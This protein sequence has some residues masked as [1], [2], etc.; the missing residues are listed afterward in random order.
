M[1]SVTYQIDSAHTHAQFKVR[2][3]MISN[4]RGEFSKVTGT[5]VYDPD[6]PSAAQ[7]NATID[8]STIS[9]R[10]PQRDEHLK[11]GDFFDVARHP[12]ITFASKEVTASGPESFE[13]TGDLTIRGT[14]RQVAL[15]VEDVTPEAKDPWGN[16]RRGASAKTRIVRKDFGLEWNMALE[17]GGF[18]VG[19]EVEITIDVELIR[20]AA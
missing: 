20:Q 19:E 7:V 10:E 16:L 12:A 6:N 17:A 11:S 18:V 1:A 14:T 3:L 5:V 9:T 2:H 8:V 15:A 4:V 13:V